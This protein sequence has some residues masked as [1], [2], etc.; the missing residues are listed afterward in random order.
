MISLRYHQPYK[1]LAAKHGTLAA[2]A[3]VYAFHIL[4]YGTGIMLGVLGAPMFPAGI[5]GSLGCI[6]CI[7]LGGYAIWIAAFLFVAATAGF[8]KL[9]GRR[10]AGEEN[11]QGNSGNVQSLGASEDAT[12]ALIQWAAISFLAVGLI[13]GSCLFAFSLSAQSSFSP[14]ALAP[15]VVCLAYGLLCSVSGRVG[16]LGLDVEAAAEEAARPD[17]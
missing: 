5:F 4:V 6:L 2:Q 14:R 8:N 12:G 15:S 17:P 1:A 10:R 13:L 9:F 11:E 3:A 7:L 16:L